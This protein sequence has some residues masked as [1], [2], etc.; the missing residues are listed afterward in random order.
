[1][2]KTG[3]TLIVCFLTI[4]S[5]YANNPNLKEQL[6]PEWKVSCNLPAPTNFISKG[7][8]S[9]TVKLHWDYQPD[10]VGGYRI[11]TFRSSDNL[12]V[13]TIV[14]G[15]DILEVVVDG[16]A[17]NTE[18]YSRISSICSDGSY[19]T[20]YS[21]V[22]FITLIVEL[23]VIGY[24]GSNT[25]PVCTINSNGGSC[26]FSNASGFINKF[27]V[28]RGAIVTYF[29]VEFKPGRIQVLRPYSD[30]YFTFSCDGT[31]FPSPT[32]C[33]V[34][35]FVEMDLLEDYFGSFLVL[36][37]E[38]YTATLSATFVQGCQNCSIQYLGGS[39]ENG[40]QAPPTTY[41]GQR[42]GLPNTPDFAAVMPNPFNDRL[43][44]W[45]DDPSVESVQCQLFNINGQKVL[46]QQFQGAQ[47]TYE[48]I[49]ENL[50]NGFYLLRV[51]ANGMVQTL[52]V[53]KAE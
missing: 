46:D 9:T 20:N 35:T 26:M 34:S 39:F 12:L 6:T 25:S 52:R 31:S 23:V 47:D 44:V 13:S 10:A 24:Q 53:I 5:L 29:G 17:S 11:Q 27:K 4:F 37:G 38:E 32:K 51:E 28:T 36:G 18:Y 19:S 16:L 21:E 30:P 22:E 15:Q 48:L 49:T 8:G 1:M 50:A 3:L 42:S 40:L 7:I 43:Q 41:E 45:V 14:K 2:K 33:T